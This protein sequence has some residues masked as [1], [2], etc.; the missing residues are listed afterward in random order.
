MNG[1]EAA[2]SYT[3]KTPADNLLTV[4]GDD[5]DEFFNNLNYLVTDKDELVKTLG[6]LQQAVGRAS[7]EA[8]D[9]APS[10]RGGNS[11]PRRTSKPARSSS[12]DDNTPECKHG[13]MVYKAGTSKAGKD[14]A[15]FFCPDND[16]YCKPVWDN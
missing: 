15:G 13:E 2:F 6:E 16:K 12:N 4:R 8:V 7:A 10:R 3:L 1:T 11:T 5:Y 14:Y 9:H